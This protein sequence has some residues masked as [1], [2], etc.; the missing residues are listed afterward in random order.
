MRILYTIQNVPRLGWHTKLIFLYSEKRKRWLL[1]VWYFKIKILVY[2]VAFGYKTLKI[3]IRGTE[4]HTY[5]WHVYRYVSYSAHGHS[6]AC[7]SA[8][9]HLCPHHVSSQVYDHIN[10][11]LLPACLPRHFVALW[12]PVK[13]RWE[14]TDIIS[15]FLQNKHP[16][17]LLVCP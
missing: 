15:A 5:F 12:N 10:D 3:K 7:N 6:G 17:W 11:G 1:S 9:K 13:R 16:Y 8:Q 2:K 4:R 14:I